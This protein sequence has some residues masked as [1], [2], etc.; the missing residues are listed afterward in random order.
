MV[1]LLGVIAEH[2]TFR[3]ATPPVIEVMWGIEVAGISLGHRVRTSD[4]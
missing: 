4:P 1:G 2:V 3:G